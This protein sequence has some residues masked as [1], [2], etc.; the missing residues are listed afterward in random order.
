MKL[1]YT[2]NKAVFLAPK[3]YGLITNDNRQIIKIKGLTKKSIANLNIE[4]IESLLYKNSYME[5]PNIKWFKSIS[6][7]NITIKDQLYSLKV[8]ANKRILIYDSNEK[9]INTKPIIINF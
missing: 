1:E 2:C 6:N 4:D 5:I 7:G 9:L 8:T 3:V